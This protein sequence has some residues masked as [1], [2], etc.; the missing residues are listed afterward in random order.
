MIFTFF[1]KLSSARREDWASLESTTEI[2]A[3]YAKQHTETRWLSMKYVAVRI[4]E[5]YDNIKEYFLKF[6]P[7]EK[8]F[9]YN[10]KHTERYKRIENALKD[11]LTEGYIAFCAFSAGDFESFLLPFQINEPKIHLLYPAMCKLISNLMNKFIRKRFLS[12]IYPD[13]K[14]IDV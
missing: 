1:F 14:S 10:I 12:V 9:K 11:P 2:A 4:L 6:L 13:N 7:K 3:Q 5:Q 8:N